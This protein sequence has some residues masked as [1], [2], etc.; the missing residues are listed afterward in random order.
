MFSQVHFREQGASYNAFKADV[1]AC[2]ITL[3]AMAMRYNPFDPKKHPEKKL[4]F[5]RDYCIR[6]WYG[7]DRN[8]IFDKF[9]DRGSSVTPELRDLILKMLEPDP[10]KRITME[11]V[12]KHPF[13]TGKPVEKKPKRKVLRPTNAFKYPKEIQKSKIPPPIQVRRSPR[14]HGK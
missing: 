9:E 4:D 1:W 6:C 12:L 10:S 3:Y 8:A 14:G 5:L 2:G 13:V 11:D 7:R